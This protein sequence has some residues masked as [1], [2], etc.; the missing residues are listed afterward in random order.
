MERTTN[1][2]IASL[3]QGQTERTLHSTKK[4]LIFLL[5]LFLFAALAVS[6]INLYTRQPYE[7]AL[8]AIGAGKIRRQGS[9]SWDGFDTHG[10]FFRDGMCYF[11]FP[12]LESGKMQMETILQKDGW[13]SLPADERIMEEIENLLHSMVF[14]N[15]MTE[16]D[17]AHILEEIGRVTAGGWFFN[18]KNDKESLKNMDLAWTFGG[19]KHLTNFVIAVYDSETGCIYYFGKDS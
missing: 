15:H 6:L 12:L 2:P 9:Y 16:K 18:D 17:S 14:G 10:G 7:Q 19:G 11:R 1:P 8:D 4:K 3:P 5:F 13:H